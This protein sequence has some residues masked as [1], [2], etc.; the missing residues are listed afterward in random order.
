MASLRWATAW[1]VAE[2]HCPCARDLL[3][4]RPPPD[5]SFWRRRLRPRR[6]H[7]GDGGG[8]RARGLA[9]AASA[10]PAFGRS[11]RAEVS[12]ASDPRYQL[13][14]L[15]RFTSA[16]CGQGT[17]YSGSWLKMRRKTYDQPRDTLSEL[18]GRGVCGRCTIMFMD[19]SSYCVCSCPYQRDAECSVQRCAANGAALNSAHSSNRM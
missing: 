15:R 7:D 9:R 10:H 16:Q 5:R 12:D 2:N 13:L 8:D 6:T 4:S 19:S 14:I 11:P 1:K 17:P 3:C 18:Q